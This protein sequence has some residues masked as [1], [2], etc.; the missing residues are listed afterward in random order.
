MICLVNDLCKMNYEITLIVAMK[1]VYENRVDASVNIEE[2]DFA[3]EIMVERMI[4]SL[5]KRGAY[6]VNSHA[7]SGIQIRLLKE[8]NRNYL[9]YITEHLA[10]FDDS[11]YIDTRKEY[12][13]WAQNTD[14]VITVSLAGRRAFQTAVVQLWIIV[15]CFDKYYKRFCLEFQDT[16]QSFPS[17]RKIYLRM[18]T[19]KSLT[20]IK[21][22]C[23]HFG[24]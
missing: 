3:N 23:L 7:D 13:I 11:E 4:K 5:N 12:F 20:S 14:K 9:L 19:I 15:I 18:V 2:C 8:Q 1:S 16:K 6:I 17:L 22:S 21:I 10:I 24:Q